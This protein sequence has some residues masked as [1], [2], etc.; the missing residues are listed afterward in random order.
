MILS[1]HQPV[2]L[3]GIIVM[4]KI[5]LSDKFMFV[6]HCDYQPK[7]W[8]SRNYIWGCRGPV[9]LS[10]PVIKGNSINETRPLTEDRWR[11]KH[12]RSIEW[13]YTG[14][15]YFEKYYPEIMACLLQPAESLSELNI[16]LIRVLMHMLEID[17]P[18]YDSID[19]V[20]KIKSHKTQMLVE[21][22]Q[23]IDD[24]SHYLS[25]PGETYVKKEEMNG[26]GHSFLKFNHPVYDQGHKEFMPNLSV[27]DLLFNMGPKSAAII[28]SC[29]TV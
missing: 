27:I 29:A 16:G 28:R 10:V 23:T 7:T 12:M 24:I 25:S 9:M 1:G 15:P 19:F 13:N 5:A 17:T 26:Y 14:R 11:L 4:S 2:Y 21:M 18:I 22:C 6:S 20:D 8:H 3:P